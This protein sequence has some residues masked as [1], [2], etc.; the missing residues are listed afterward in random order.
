[1]QMLTK[2]TATRRGRFIGRAL[3]GTGMCLCMSVCMHVCM[4]GAWFTG[5]A[6]EG[7][8][9]HACTNVNTCPAQHTISICVCVYVWCVCVC[10]CVCVHIHVHT[11]GHTYTYTDPYLPHCWKRGQRPAG[12]I[13]SRSFPYILQCRRVILLW[14]SCFANIGMC[15]CL[16]MNASIRVYVCVCITAMVSIRVYVNVHVYDLAMVT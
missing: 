10:V 6:L 4:C 5:H 14:L 11:Y 15:A 1:M 12:Q 7:T 8:G 9:M 16:R 13:D 2:R 3:E